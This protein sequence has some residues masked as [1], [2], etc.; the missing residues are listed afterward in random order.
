MSTKR[1]LV[2]LLLLSL[3]LLSIGVAR[4]D[5]IHVVQPGDTLYE[6]AQLYGVSMEEIAAA[7]NL[8]NIRAVMLGYPLII[9]GVDGPLGAEPT[10]TPRPLTTPRPYVVP[11]SAV[12]VPGGVQHTVEAG[13]TLFRISMIYNV[14]MTTIAE[15]NDLSDGRTVR[16]GRKLFI[17]GA[18]L[19]GRAGTATAT[20]RPVAGATAAAGAV[21]ATGGNLFKNGD[22]E[23]DWY[24]YL[25][26]ELQVPTG[27]QL[28]TDEGPNTLTPGSGG[29]FNRPEVRVVGTNQ[30]PPNEWDWFVL[31][32]TKAV[33]V[34]KGGAPTAFSMFQDVY[35]Q[36]G[37][38]RMTLNFFPDL[39][40]DYNQGG[41]RSWVTDPLAGEV[42][43]IHNNSG[44]SNWS[45]VT[46]GQQNNRVYEFTVTQAGAHRLG[47]AFRNRFETANNG[48]FLDD[49]RLER[50]G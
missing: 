9:P 16:L 23:G 21:A 15:A 6:I 46:A 28:A 41:Q 12:A 33:K 14:A 44:S 17:P 50:I 4:A 18:T 42:S 43:I 3:L 38:Y 10:T 8:A 32:G 37:R 39:V 31:N 26:N 34:F 49:W 47:A 29:L 2:T 35:L 24:F 36:P 45:T 48:W 13:D 30:L 27:W 40:A 11:T 7:N 19:G 20:P 22:F 1:L 5:T 25:Y